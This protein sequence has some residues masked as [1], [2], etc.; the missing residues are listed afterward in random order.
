MLE[1]EPGYPAGDLQTNGIQQSDTEAVLRELVD[2]PLRLPQYQSTGKRVIVCREADLSGA[3]YLPLST[4]YK[5]SLRGK[6]NA[7]VYFPV[8]VVMVIG[9]I[10]A[11]NDNLWAINLLAALVLINVVLVAAMNLLVWPLLVRRHQRKCCSRHVRG[12][13]ISFENLYDPT[14]RPR[15]FNRADSPAERRRKMGNFYPLWLVEDKG[16]KQ[17]RVLDRKIPERYLQTEMEKIPQTA[18]VWFDPRGTEM[19]VKAPKKKEPS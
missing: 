19:I 10:M 3:E 9:A 12:R 17:L 16:K 6:L 13:L 14:L 8:I 15:R 7:M 4:R 2:V 11:F 1:H 18:E 5:D